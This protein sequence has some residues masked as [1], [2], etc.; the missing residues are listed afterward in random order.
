MYKFKSHINTIPPNHKNMLH[1][2]KLFLYKL[3]MCPI[4]EN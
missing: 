1:N 3:R 4:V 2:Y